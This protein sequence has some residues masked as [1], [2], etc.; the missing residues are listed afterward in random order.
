MLFDTHVEI[1]N[2]ITF[3]AKLSWNLRGWLAVVQT[4]TCFPTVKVSP[5]ISTYDSVNDDIYNS[6]CHILLA[7]VTWK[8][9][10]L[11]STGARLTLHSSLKLTWYDTD[12]GNAVTVH[13]GLDFKDKSWKNPCHKD[14]QFC[15]LF[16]CVHVVLELIEER[17]QERSTKVCQGWTKG[18]YCSCPSYSENSFSASYQFIVLNLS[19]ERIAA[20]AYTSSR[21]AK[22]SSPL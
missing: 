3:L 10:I 2:Y 7:W 22:R 14:P 18:I 5:A 15:H 1:F 17:S 11:P 8:Q 9:C 6:V 13:V 20:K 21:L 4:Q 16:S 12:K 19:V